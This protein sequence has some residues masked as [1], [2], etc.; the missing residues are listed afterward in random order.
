MR[1][2]SLLT[3]LSMG[4]CTEHARAQFS[5]SL[6]LRVGTNVTVATQNYQPLWLVSNRFGTITDQQADVS[7]Y[8]SFTNRHVY[9]GGSPLYEYLRKYEKLPVV[10]LEY[11]LDLY[12]NHHFQQVFI[13]E[14]YVKVNYNHWQLRAGRYE[15][16]IGEVNPE[17]SSGSFGISGNALPVPKVSL[18]I[19]QYTDVPF[20][21]G[22]LQVKGLFSH[23]W[24]GEDR[25][26]KE[27]LLH[28][29]NFYL[30][31][32]TPAFR[33]YGGLNRF[34]VWGGKHPD[35][36]QLPKTLNDYKIIVLGRP[37]DDARPYREEQHDQRGNHLGFFDFGLNL[38]LYNMK[39][40]VYQQTP[41]ED[42]SGV[43]PLG[44]PDKLLG[45]ALANKNPGSLL[46]AVTV[47]YM[48][49]RYQGGNG[50]VGKDN[51]FNNRLYSSGWTYAGRVIGTPLFTDKDR[52]A[53]YFEED[54]VGAD[55]WQVV[56]NKIRGIHLGWKGRLLPALHLRTLLTYT[57]NY[58]NNFNKGQFSPY[59]S[60]WYFMQEVVYHYYHWKLNA[61]LGIDAGELTRNTGL[62]FGV[63]YDL[64]NGFPLRRHAPK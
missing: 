54:V 10:A 55:D 8:I 42:R 44:N 43:K 2:I 33:L 47:E 49:T 34:A 40:T 21:N 4:F 28:E 20:T 62:L 7:T 36:G 57:E 58:G 56:N 32:G 17:L 16:N 46:S 9:K 51:Y 11:G 1:I 39:I 53:V 19:M 27:A 61:A 26:V 22:W 41:F 18:A 6:Q 48:D 13:Q 38:D 23:G 29:R 3:I 35:Y 24:M 5:D 30:R 59:K 37:V 15:E 52:A 64:K 60:Q 31:L 63:S 12:H 14:G 25:W 50:K 45:I